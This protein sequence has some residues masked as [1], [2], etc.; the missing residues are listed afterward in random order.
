M[1][2]LMVGG[3]NAGGRFSVALAPD[4]KALA[5]DN[6]AVIQLWEVET[7]KALRRPGP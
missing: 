1:L 3:D 4:G 6:G 5:A 2:Q 7:G